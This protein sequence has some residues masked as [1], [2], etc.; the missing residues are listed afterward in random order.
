VKVQLHPEAEEELFQGAAWY[1]DR[2]IGLGDD[3]LDEV[4]RWLDVIAESPTTWPRWPG[5]PDLGVPVRRVVLD[6]F[7]YSIAYQAFPEHVWVVA[8][9]HWSKAPFYWMRRVGSAG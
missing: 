5:S 7:P 3:L 6:Q 2:E 4:A 8:I 9:A 1:D